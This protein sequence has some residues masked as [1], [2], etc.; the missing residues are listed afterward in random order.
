MYRYI[1]PFITSNVNINR[2]MFSDDVIEAILKEQPCVP[3]RINF[4]GD[5]NKEDVNAKQQT[6]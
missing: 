5:P 2:N 3:V 6:S 4:T 1:G